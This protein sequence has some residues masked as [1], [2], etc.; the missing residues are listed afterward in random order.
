MR[1]RLELT[2][3]TPLMMHNEQLSDGDNE[4]SKQIKELTAKRTN[5]TEQ[6]KQTVSKLEWFGGLYTNGSREPV[7]PTPNIVKCLRETASATKEG[8]KITRGISPVALHS[9][10]IYDGPRDIKLL[11]ENPAFVD[12]RQVK[13]QSG[14]IKRTRPI[15][16]EWSLTAEFELLTDVLDFDR[17]RDIADLAGRATGLGDGRIIGFG[18]FTS[19]VTR[20]RR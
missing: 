19:E 20:P 12:R 17:L 6:D 5:Q 2:G 13:I 3:T 10:L 8:R 11:Y 14:R 18:R 4:F 16:P 7:V 9:P 15:F 1:V